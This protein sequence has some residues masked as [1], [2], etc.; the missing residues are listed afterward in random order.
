MV[1]A[2]GI[3]V[4]AAASL[5]AEHWLQEAP[6]PLETVRFDGD[7]NRVRESDLREALADQLGGGLL[8]VDVGGVRRAVESLAWVESAA[9]RRVWPDTLRITVTEQTPVARWGGA[10]LM[11][12]DA[13]VFRPRALPAGLPS[14]SGPPGSAARVL[15]KYRRLRI[16]LAPLGLAPSGLTLDERRAWT[17][18]LENGGT[19]RLGREETE[20]RMARLIDAWPRITQAQS[21]SVAVVDLRYPNGFALRWQDED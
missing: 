20:A 2:L 14:L 16:G 10:A 8:G 3:A 1:L 7:L 19:L 6:L 17:V 12:T 4:A 18:S 15:A 11:N 13:Q 21:R 5:A 9:V